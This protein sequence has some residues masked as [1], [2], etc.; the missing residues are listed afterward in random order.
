VSDHAL[1]L[2]AIFRTPACAA[3]LS[4]A[5]LGELLAQVAAVQ[6]TLTA[7]LI[8]DAGN[9]GDTEANKPISQSQSQAE[10]L[11]AVPEVA[12]MLGYA[13]SYVYE[14]LRRGDL[15]AVRHKKYVRV[16]HSAVLKFI[17]QHEQRGFDST[18]SNML[19]ERR[20]GK[21]HEAPPA[22]AR[23]EANG[24]RQTSRRAS[25]DRQSMGARNGV[26]S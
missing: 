19:S 6:S 7:R 5:M 20:D 17:A 11:L 9:H 10:R 26:D 23:A 21:R 14:L 12:V 16:R 4:R 3:E 15:P 25:D 2:D 18:L 24:A 13:K 8:T 22:G 1:T